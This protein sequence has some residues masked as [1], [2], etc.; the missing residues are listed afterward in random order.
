MA[1]VILVLHILIIAVHF[2]SHIHDLELYLSSLTQTQRI[3]H[4]QRYAGSTCMCVPVLPAEREWWQL[5][6]VWH[7]ANW[8]CWQQ[9]WH[10]QHAALHICLRVDWDGS[11]K[12]KWERRAPSHPEKVRPKE[13]NELKA[14]LMHY[15]I[16]T[17]MNS[18][19]RLCSNGASISKSDIT[20]LALWTLAVTQ[21]LVNDMTHCSLQRCISIKFHLFI[22][23]QITT[24]I[25]SMLFIL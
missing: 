16:M 22:Y 6:Y 5:P 15:V 25:T 9:G 18:T 1:A 20:Q 24:E 8:C 10:L 19:I 11:L 12:L 2:R 3:N 14:A 4:K 7:L 17:Q 13:W 23:C 21:Q